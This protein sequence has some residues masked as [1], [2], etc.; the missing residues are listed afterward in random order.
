MSAL[1]VAPVSPEL[2]LRSFDSPSDH[3]CWVALPANGNRY[4]VT[5]G[6]LYMSTVPGTTI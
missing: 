1:S 6:V 3:A 2:A 5:D 4:D